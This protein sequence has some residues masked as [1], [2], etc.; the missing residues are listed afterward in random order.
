L[1][2][3]F[4]IDSAAQDVAAELQKLGCASVIL[5]TAANSESQSR[6]AGGLMPRGELVIA[7]LGGE[8]PLAISGLS[9]IIGERSVS[10]T[11][12]GSSHDSEDALAF[13]ALQG[14]RAMVET[15][16]MRP[17]VPRGKPLERD[18][19]VTRYFPLSLAIYFRAGSS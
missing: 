19:L 12:T 2:A 1:G 18:A 9:L 3:H 8:T 14:I 7:G 5:A 13:S 17:T 15:M 6:L 4:Y 10:G 16:R 11:L